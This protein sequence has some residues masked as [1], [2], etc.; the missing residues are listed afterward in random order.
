MRA[1]PT[2]ALAAAAALA[3]L[4]LLAGCATTSGRHATTLSLDA[5]LAGPRP[6]ADRRRDPDRHPV[7]TLL[8]FGLRPGSRVLQV[9]PRSGYYTRIIAPLVRRHGRFVAALIAPARSR[10]LATRNARYRQMLAAQP[11]E[12]GRVHVVTFPLDGGNA[13]PPGSV[14]LVLACGTLHQW[15]ARGETTQAL[16]TVYQALA[17]GGVLGIVDN[18]AAANAPLDP[19]AQ[20]GYVHQSYAIKLIET[21]GF[22]LV[23]TS[24]VNANPRDT[25]AYPAGAWTLP[26]AYRLGRIHH[27]HY[28]AI[29]EPDRFTLKFVKP[30]RR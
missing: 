13:V 17:P 8:F 3:A 15:M 7:R 12:F 27:R 14:N 2:A 1:L 18:R 11:Q 21:A 20:D 28:A 9:W 29:G 23:A 22:T 6:A 25:K 5:I 4:V 19:R 24:E 16:R 26:P 30:G 10:F